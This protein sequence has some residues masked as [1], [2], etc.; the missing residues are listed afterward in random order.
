MTIDS[1]IAQ[2]TAQSEKQL[3]MLQTAKQKIQENHQTGKVVQIEGH[4]NQY[5]LIIDSYLGYESGLSSLPVIMGKVVRCNK[6][7]KQLK[8]AKPQTEIL[9][10]LY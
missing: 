10:F 1:Q 5:F 9:E 3:Q 6:Q 2:H 7:G 4:V 8:T